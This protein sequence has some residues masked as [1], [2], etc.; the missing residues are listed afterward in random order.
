MKRVY[1]PNLRLWLPLVVLLAI[2]PL[3]T[4]LVVHQY[5]DSKQALRESSYNDV[6]HHIA[7]IQSYISQALRRHEMD[8]VDLIVTSLATEVVYRHAALF[9]ETG[10]V[11]SATHY[12]WKQK[13]IA[14]VAEGFDPSLLRHMQRSL[15]PVIEFSSPT[16]IQA[17]FPVRFPSKGKLRHERTGGLY[18]DYDFSREALRLEQRLHDQLLIYWFGLLAA[19]GLIL[20]LLYI[21]VHAPLRRLVMATRQLGEGRLDTRVEIGGKGELAMLADSFNAMVRRLD[22]ASQQLRILSAA[23]QQA[24]EVVMITDPEGCIEYVNPS[25]SRVTGYASSEA[26]GE[27]ISLLKS[28]E[29]PPRYYQEMWDAITQGQHW[30]SKIV[31]RRKDGSLYSSMM[32]I[33]PVFDARGAINHFVCIQQDMS[34]YEALEQQL[35]QSQ[36]LEAIGTLVG[37]IAHEFN[38]ALA[39]IMGRVYLARRE[40]EAGKPVEHSLDDIDRLSERAAGMVRQLLAYSRKGG[41]E[42]QGIELTAFVR[43]LLKLHKVV[44]P[45][46]IDLQVELG[47][48]ALPVK[49]DV[50][51]LQQVLVNLL[52]NA[53]DAVAGRDAPRVELRL[54]AWHADATFLARHEQAEVRD[55][56]HLTVRDNGSGIRP[57]DLERIFDPFFTTKEVGQGTG[58]G[59]SMVLGAVQAHDGIVEAHSRPEGGA[60]FDVYLPLN[61]EAIATAD[62]EAVPEAGSEAGGGET[63]LLVDD[64]ATVRQTTAQV[65]GTFGY[66][67]LTAADGREGLALFHEHAGEV[68]LVL[69]DI[70][71]PRMGGIAMVREIRRQAPDIAVL[72]ATGYDQG[73]VAGEDV[74][75]EAVIG[76]PFV[77]A[78]LGGRLRQLLQASSGK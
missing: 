70:V 72:Y 67:V 56:A 71:M 54:R 26:V 24:G 68:A 55:Y 32:S 57:E 58:L 75:A 61:R 46:D 19:S 25:F 2:L 31:N 78:E 33:S 7:H 39:A 12:T 29:Q 76:K 1:T 40:V 42:M 34:D 45:E 21:W 35:R 44:L 28:G 8:M 73:Q 18:I 11:V 22:D 14:K 60:Q 52:N 27:K 15:Q 65:L 13:P 6:R 36:K 4:A 77:P 64:E 30:S 69:T 9:D 51:Q 41:I 74:D 63:I 20:L 48:A 47:D 37:G 49:G 3:G 43:D 38:N 5:I 17:W 23:M 16:S 53:R 62:P 50:S 10:R 66:R 59:L